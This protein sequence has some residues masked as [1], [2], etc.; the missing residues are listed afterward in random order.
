M[1]NTLLFKKANMLM[2]WCV[3][4][5]LLPMLSFGQASLPVSRTAWAAP[6]PTGWTNSGCTQRTSAF[7]CTGNNGTI[8]DTNGDSRILNFSGTPNQLI[9]KLKKSSMSGESKLILTESADGITY[10]AA[11]G[12]YGTA[13]GATAIT[14]CGDITVSLLSTTRFIKWTYTKAGGNCDM[15]DVSVTA[16][17]VIISGGTTSTTAFTTTYGTA[18][19]SQSVAVSGTLLSNDLVA[20]AQTGFEV[21]R[22]NVVLNGTTSNYTDT[23]SN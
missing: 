1:K 18:S 23:E 14:D 13:S 19:A 10:S 21:S 12:T 6:E 3:A 9:F 2:F 11:I 17:S 8:F 20:T 5:F 7:A 15:D 4:L 22:N 16:P